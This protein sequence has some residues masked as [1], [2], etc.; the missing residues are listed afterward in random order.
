MN[1]L[2]SLSTALVYT[3]I[4][5]GLTYAHGELGRGSV[6]NLNKSTS[7]V[8]MSRIFDTKLNLYQVSECC[9]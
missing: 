7:S 6:K 3:H 2:L 9:K 1:R 5:K 8:R 4:N